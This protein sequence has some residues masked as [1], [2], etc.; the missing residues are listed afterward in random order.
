MARKVAEWTMQN[1]M[2]G[3][4]C[5]YYQLRPRGAVK[6]SFMRWGQAWMAFALAR[7]IEAETPAVRA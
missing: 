7:L 1:M 2:D 4:G 3:S 6:K 5:F